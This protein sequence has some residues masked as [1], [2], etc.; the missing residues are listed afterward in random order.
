MKSVQNKKVKNATKIEVD[1]I[2]FRSKL[3]AYT[4]K[5]LKQANIDA[6]YEMHRYTLLPAFTFHGNKVRAI[7][8]LPDFVGKDFIIECKG[9]PNDAFPLKEKLFKR[10]L[11]DISPNC[12]YYVVHTQKEVN[13]LVEQLKQKNC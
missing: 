4:Y 12:M 2:L 11:V 3:E 10:L 6:E 5:K 13:T 8:Y 9:F 7:T 1:G